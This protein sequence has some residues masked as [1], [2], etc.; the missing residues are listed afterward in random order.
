MVF[1]RSR[2]RG[3]LLRNEPYTE[4]EGGGRREIVMAI[5]KDHYSV[6]DVNSRGQR[7]PGIISG[8]TTTGWYNEGNY[9]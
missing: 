1:R 5:V 6:R 2:E 3:A 7:Y 9:D 4:G 8:I